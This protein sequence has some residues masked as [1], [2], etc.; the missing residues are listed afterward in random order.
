MRARA[1][2]RVRV[3]VRARFLRLRPGASAPT[4]ASIFL[5]GCMAICSSVTLGLY[6]YVARKYSHEV[7]SAA[8]DSY[9]HLV[10]HGKMA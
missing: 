4:R 1:L 3:L 9:I 6:V 7:L 10:S 5:S 2:S 8:C